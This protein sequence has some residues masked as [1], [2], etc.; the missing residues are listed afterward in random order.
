ME[1]DDIPTET[2]RA[3]ADRIQETTDRVNRTLARIA[4]ERP[5][6]DQ[7]LAD[8]AER[9]KASHQNFVETKRR[10]EEFM[11]AR[12]AKAAATQAEKE[13]AGSAL[14]ETAGG[15]SDGANTALIG[16]AP[17]A[18]TPSDENIAVRG[19]TA[20]ATA[21]DAASTSKD[22][23]AGNDGSATGHLPTATKSSTASEAPAPQDSASLPVVRGNAGSPVSA[24]EDEK[25]RSQVKGWLS[26]IAQA[27]KRPLRKRRG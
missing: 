24:K 19:D 2:I 15:T 3:T 8:L 25:P 12:A 13:G 22:T 1:Y 17:V 4:K 9:S 21:T 16:A 27:V 7:E 10:F 14:P 23:A 11:A 6:L 5:L 20:T 26:R 18:N